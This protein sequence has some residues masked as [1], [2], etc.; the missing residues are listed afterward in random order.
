MKP[1]VVFDRKK[2]RSCFVAIVRLFAYCYLYCF[3]FS[4][5]FLFLFP[6]YGKRWFDLFGTVLPTVDFVYVAT[7][8]PACV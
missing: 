1:T 4:F 3:S 2:E 5:F 6:Q 7:N 8:L